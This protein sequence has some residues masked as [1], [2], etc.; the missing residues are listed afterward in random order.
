MVGNRG[1]DRN[2]QHEELVFW[3]GRR[4]VE[5]VAIPAEFQE[6]IIAMNLVNSDIRTN[7]AFDAFWDRLVAAWE[8]THSNHQ[9]PDI[10]TRGR[11]LVHCGQAIVWRAADYHVLPSVA[12]QHILMLHM[13]ADLA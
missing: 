7:E 8:S 11:Q 10:Y 9:L 2:R 6:L 12:T 13:A 4:M 1:I 3:L 5:A